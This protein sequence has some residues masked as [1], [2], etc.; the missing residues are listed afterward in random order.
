[1]DSATDGKECRVSDGNR[2]PAT[3]AINIF[4]IAT[5]KEPGRIVTILCFI[6]CNISKT[7]FQSSIN[8]KDIEIFYACI[9]CTKLPK[10]SMHLTLTGQPSS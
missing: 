8:I 5:C 2:V 3:K 4:L 10:F 9:F 7:L 6:K 1:M